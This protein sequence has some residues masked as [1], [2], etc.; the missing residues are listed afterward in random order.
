MKKI[1]V[2][3]FMVLGFAFAANAQAAADSKVEEKKSTEVQVDQS[4]VNNTPA[5]TPTATAA[6]KPV[7][8]KE[9]A[10]KEGSSC[11]KKKESGSSCCKAKTGASA[12]A[13]GSGEAKAEEGGAAKSGCSKDGEHKECCKKKAET[14]KSGS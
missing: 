14:P 9:C 7:E 4:A 8:K 12:S 5:S 13:S 3:S 10:G 11:C 2:M 1:F 6:D